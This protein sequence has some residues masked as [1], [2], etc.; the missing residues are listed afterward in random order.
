MLLLAVPV[1][2]Y[3]EKW[4]DVYSETWLYQSSKSRK[5]LNYRSD[6]AYDADNLQ[7]SLAGNVTVW[8]REVADVAGKTKGK[9]IPERETTFKKVH[10][11][12]A[13]KKYEIISA[14]E[15]EGG[16]VEA[17]GEEVRPGTIYEK[18][19]DACCDRK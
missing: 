6:Y 8:L 4:V 18:L 2:L 13:A 16:L 1:S 5:K 3:A 14:D 17:M 19:Y 15:S 9:K 12:C 10:F 7:K 11:W